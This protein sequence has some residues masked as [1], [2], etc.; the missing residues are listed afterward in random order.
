MGSWVV[1]ASS[2]NI[3]TAWSKLRWRPTTSFSISIRPKPTGAWSSRV[4]QLPDRLSVGPIRWRVDPVSST[5]IRP[6]CQNPIESPRLFLHR[7]ADHHAFR[8]VRS[9]ETGLQSER[10]FVLCQCTL[11]KIYWRRS[12]L[13]SLFDPGLKTQEL[14]L[15]RMNN[16]LQI[17]DLYLKDVGDGEPILFL[18]GVPDSDKFRTRKWPI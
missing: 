6:A 9:Q 17:V 2:N 4:S 14:N 5:Q 11:N 13:L 12:L 3:G 8:W 18:H 1:T 15:S 16:T 10:Q 7:G